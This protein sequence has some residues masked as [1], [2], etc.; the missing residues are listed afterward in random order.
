MLAGL[1][2]ISNETPGAGGEVG[3]IPADE[4]TT[5]TKSAR[6]LYSGRA[7]KN[8]EKGNFHQEYERITKQIKE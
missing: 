5:S 4:L 2:V 3:L 7:I 6:E 1:R 8:F